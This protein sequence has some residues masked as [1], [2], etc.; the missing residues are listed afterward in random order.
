MK[1]LIKLYNENKNKIVKI[2]DTPILHLKE[3]LNNI[4]IQ[5]SHEKPYS[6]RR[7]VITGGTYQ[8]LMREFADG[9]ESVTIDFEDSY[10]QLSDEEY[11]LL[12]DN[13]RNL[14]KLY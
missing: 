4:Y 9:Q 5:V 2:N 8:D 1:E 3:N 6:M 11:K 14:R 13:I 7:V 10:F 12:K